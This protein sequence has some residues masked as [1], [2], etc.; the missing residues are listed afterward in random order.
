MSQGRYAT[1]VAKMSPGRAHPTHSIEV[2]R[3]G[4]PKIAKQKPNTP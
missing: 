2:P 4:P 1:G 3:A